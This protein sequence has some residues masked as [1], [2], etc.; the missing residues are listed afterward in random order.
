MSCNSRFAVA[1]HIAGVLAYMQPRRLTSEY[2]AYSVIT[3]PVVIRRVL[4]DLRRAGLVTS[5]TGNGGGWQ[6]QRAPDS[7]TLLHIYEAVRDGRLLQI[8]AQPP[9]LQCTVGA[10]VRQALLGLF[11]EAEAALEAKL[12][13][14]TLADVLARVQAQGCLPDA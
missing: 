1:I 7:I 12:A 10:G 11:D 5:Q 4:G 6:L 3:N 2:I 14:T 8:H 9:N 13:R